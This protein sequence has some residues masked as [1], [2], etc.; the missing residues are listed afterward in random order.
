MSGHGRVLGKIAL[1]AG[2]AS[3]IGR[4]TATLL[5]GHGATVWCSDL[6]AAGAATTAKSIGG[7]SAGLDVTREAEWEAVIAAVVAE[8]GRLDVLVNSAGISFGCAVADMSLDDWQRVLRVN[9]DGAFLGT[10]HG[11][12]AMRGTGG[13]IVNVSSASGLKSA[14]GAA[15]YSTS[16]AAV[17]MLTRTA[18]KECVDAGLAIRVNTVC[19]GGVR[20]PLWRTMPF[21]QELIAK[22][23]SEE[24]AFQAILAGGPAGARFAEPEEIAHAILYLASDESRFVTGSDLVIDAGFRA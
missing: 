22:S 24:A 15:A 5:A 17:C 11:I 10:K 2:A 19:P 9:L 13:A 14:P 3:G 8:H 4:A 6:N 16:K 20:T 12:R 7:K 21:F 23:G 18:A 1:V